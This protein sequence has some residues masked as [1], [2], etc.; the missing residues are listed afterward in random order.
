MAR[1]SSVQ[2]VEDSVVV[3]VLDESLQRVPRGLERREPR[4]D[5]R[6]EDHPVAAPP[7][8][9]LHADRDDDQRLCGLLE[10]ADGDERS[11][12][13]REEVLLR[14]RGEDRPEH[15][16]GQEPEDDLLRGQLPVAGSREREQ[17]EHHRREEAPEQHDVRD[18]VLH[19]GH[20]RDE[21]RHGPRERAD[22]EHDDPRPVRPDQAPVAGA[23]V[24]FGARG[25]NGWSS[26]CPSWT[27]P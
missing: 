25:V 10:Y 14:E 13:I 9:D 24:H 1:C 16:A 2:D 27:M 18:E 22:D 6:A 19:A 4:T 8:R 17:H 5:R 23:R 7:S 12:R 20:A 11:D 21:C 15:A 26:S 3:A